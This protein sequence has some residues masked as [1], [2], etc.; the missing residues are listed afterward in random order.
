M[1]PRVEEGQMHNRELQSE[2][3]QKMLIRRKLLR[4]CYF[5]CQNHSLLSFCLSFVFGSCRTIK[6]AAI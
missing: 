4:W 5:L 2:V 3:K 1:V 6:S